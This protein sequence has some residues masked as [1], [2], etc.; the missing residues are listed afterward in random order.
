MENSTPFKVQLSQ[1][2][3]SQAGY[4]A[5]SQAGYQAGYEPDSQPGFQVDSRAGK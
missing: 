1:I 2:H 3:L 5:G 4:Q